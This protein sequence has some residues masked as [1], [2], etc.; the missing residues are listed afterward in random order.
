MNCKNQK[1]EKS[2]AWK[3]RVL[4]LFL[5]V[6]TLT[7]SFLFQSAPTVAEAAES[8]F[9]IQYAGKG[10]E[11]ITLPQD[12]K[13]TIYVEEKA[14]TAYSWQFCINKSNDEWVTVSGQK[15]NFLTLS[16]AMVRS[17]SD[18]HGK[19]YVRSIMKSNGNSVISSPVCI[20]V[21][22]TAPETVKQSETASTS[23]KSSIKR[24]AAYSDLKSYTVT[25]N[26][27]YENGDRVSDP[28]VANI[29][30][31]GE[32]VTTV[33]FP[34][35]AGYLPY[36]Q[37]NEN[38]STEY[39]INIPKITQDY[40]YTVT[41]KPTLVS[42]K[43]HHYIQ[44]I[45]DDNYVLNSTTELTGLTG[46]S[47]G[48]G[49]AIDIDGFTALYYDKDI[50][51]AAD[52][53]TEIEIYYDR[54]YYLLLFNLNGG[55]GAEP[56]YTR[57]GATVSVGKPTRHGY[58][59]KGWELI[60]CGATT[61]AD[62][63]KN[64]Y[65]LNLNS[66]TVP[67]MNLKYQAVWE[68]TDT[69]YTVVYWTENA[70]DD[71][72]SYESHR[73]ADAKSGTVV[74]ESTYG[75]RA[76]AHFTYNADK[77]D[78]NVIV[79]GDGSTVVNVYYSRNLYTLTFR[80][81]TCT[82]TS[83]RHTHNDYCYSPTTIT[84]KYGA[85]IHTNFPIKDG[86]DTIWWEVPDGTETFEKGNWLGSIDTMPGENITFKEYDRE[87]GAVLYYYTET[88]SGAT[89]DITYSG[90]NY[91]LYKK[92]DLLA[93][94]YLTYKEEFHDIKGFK[95][96]DSNPKFG[97]DGSVRVRSKNYLY[98]TRKSYRLKFFNYKDYVADKEQTLQ[99]QQPLK[100]LDFT[101]DYPASLEPNAY[102][103]AGW[104]TTPDCYDGSQVDF[105]AAT[106]PDS[107]V[108][109]YA[110][111]APKTH[112]VRIFKTADKTEGE[113]IDKKLIP[114]GSYAK[115]PS[116]ILNDNYVFNGWFYMDGT[117][118]KAF[119]FNNMPVNRDLDI[120]AE[121]SSKT[122]VLY[123]VRYK[124]ADGTEIAEPTVG[125]TLAGTSKTFTAKGGA[126]LYGKYQEGYF[127][128]TGSHTIL[129]NINGGNEY[130]FIYTSMPNVPYTVRYLEKGTGKPL[131]TEKYVAENKKSVVT[132][133]F[134]Q[135]NGY[136]PDAYQKRLVVSA[137]SEENVLTFWYT[138]DD[139][140][141]YY[142]IRHLVQ[143]LEGDGY[144]EYRTIQ[145]PGAIGETITEKQLEIT[146]YTY[147]EGISTASGVLTE[148]G[149][150]LDLYYDRNLYGY[151]VRYLEY[152]TN[153]ELRAPSDY[154][155][156]YRYGTVVSA[157]AADI[158]GYTVVGE[159]NKTRTIS[160]RNNEIIFYYSEQ[161][162]TINYVPIGAGSV[163]IGSET[164]KAA[165]GSVSG[166]VPLP[167]ERYR[168]DGWFTDEDCTKPVSS[169]WI[170]ANG[171]LTP[172]KENG[173]YVSAVY[174]AKFSASTSFITIQKSGWNLAD[175]NQTFL[176]EI[177]GTDENTKSVDITVTVHE[178][179]STTITD[180]PV[181]K[182]TVTENTDWSWRYTP[183]K[184][185]QPIELTVEG[186]VLEFKNQRAE[187][188][189]LD[190]DNYS[191]NRFVTKH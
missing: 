5:C 58:V 152:G 35:V 40:T 66:V 175:E 46:T 121:W 80:K 59:F 86:D 133:K 185:A 171:K 134:E 166:S 2:G 68:T 107:D 31:D 101:P 154:N 147:N 16:Y 144:T 8:E 125:S 85:D 11:S 156:I 151:T 32:F 88:L 132:A 124:L 75:T 159:K 96:G 63:Q 163:S 25:V 91:N 42:Y 128:K 108:T 186:K 33:K 73:T 168:F 72:Y 6:T 160:D 129:M 9:K 7:A 3:C 60:E 74:N 47:V 178:N 89:G 117:E 157:D 145:G 173:L 149:L 90:K 130:T 190:G 97:D 48:D 188:K 15:K 87:S 164:V 167:A 49:C 169:E 36:F 84:A 148:G 111:W 52:G 27:I 116:D 20:N 162:V 99:Y 78:K 53:S 61:A 126:E 122:P 137:N 135:I 79:E 37:N 83:R 95:Q 181:G 161:E 10:I 179:G 4:A 165:T 115:A 131:H 34:S 112:T 140:H 177:K 41:Y 82:N 13:R 158:L 113:L 189:W 1:T 141:A 184:R 120:F 93:N 28:Y 106:M 57:Y 51:I 29:E 123:T 23:P 114:H 81:L 64:R 39:E 150:E 22:Y 176:F 56:I 92:V 110:K 138:A 76:I 103:F 30:A 180:L 187:D 109:L 170:D 155:A 153:K 105:S 65:N 174:Y 118:K 69:T 94:G 102:E 17:L 139:E 71:G 100:Y 146:G 67:S 191:I 12:D 172:Q 45:L 18:S 14:D 70:D 183:E 26:Y 24:N 50:K 98:Y 127:P 19:A 119:D 77:S 54:N 104:F 21:S 142:I 143:N 43:V 44:N 62:E 182:Y 38:S 136:M 55:Y